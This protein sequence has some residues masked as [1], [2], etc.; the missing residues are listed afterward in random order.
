MLYIINYFK[1]ILLLPDHHKKYLLSEVINY[2]VNL[3]YINDL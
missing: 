2:F 1:N 3:K